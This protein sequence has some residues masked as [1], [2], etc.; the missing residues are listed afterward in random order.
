MDEIKK[1]FCAELSKSLLEYYG[2]IPSSSAFARDFN[3]RASDQV[4]QISK[5]TARRWI[6]GLSFPEIDKLQLIVTWLELN[7][8]FLTSTKLHDLKKHGKIRQ[9][10]TAN[11]LKL[12]E[13]FRETDTRGK[14]M[15]LIMGESLSYISHH[16]NH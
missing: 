6:R 2:R 15:L 4:P 11:E 7:T 10:L 1:V 9:T 16:T 12:L 13:A 5:E 8:A 3:L 14:K